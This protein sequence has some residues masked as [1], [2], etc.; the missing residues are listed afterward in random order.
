MS[1]NSPNTSSVKNA[2]LDYRDRGYQVI[3]VPHRSKNPG[4]VDWPQLRLSREDVEKQFADQMNVGVLLGEPSGWIV[5]VDIDHPK[6][7][8]IADQYLPQTPAVF[9]RPGNPR[10]HRI[11]RVTTPVA[12]KKY[13]SKSAGTII[14]LRSTG[15]QTVFPPSTHECG[16]AIAWESDGAEPALVDP[17]Q[18]L[19]AV[20]A[21]ADQV[22]IELGEKAKPAA[23]KEKPHSQV[24]SDAEPTADTRVERCLRAMSRISTTDSNDGSSRLFTAACRCVEHDL[25]DAESIDAIRQ[26]SMVQPFPKDWSDE[27]ILKRVRDAENRCTRGEANTNQE[28]H[29]EDA[30]GLSQAARLVTLAG[31]MELFRSGDEA[32]ATFDV[33]DHRE[34]HA[35]K[36]KA[37]K[38]WLCR[39]YF[40][41]T[42]H[43][44]TSSALTDA[45]AVLNGQAMFGGKELPVA[46]RLAEHDGA[47]WLDLGDERWRAIR[48]DRTGWSVVESRN[49]PVRFLHRR[50]MRPLPEPVRGGNIGELRSFLNLRS[51]DDWA[52]CLAF[53]VGALRPSGPF[54]VLHIGGEHGTAKSSASRVLRSLIDP[55]TA[56]IRCEPKEPRDL[57]IAAS[58]AWMI[59]FD[60]LSGL[61]SW[62]SDALCRLA[63][64]GGFSTRELYSDGDETIFNAK[65]PVILNGIETIATKPDLLDRCINLTLELIP[66]N[67]RRTESDLD[68][69]FD[70]A[71][72]RILGALLD[73]VAM[74]MSRCAEV[75]LV[76]LPRMADFAVWVVAAEPALGLKPGAFLEAYGRDRAAAH[77]HTVENSALA[78]AINLLLDGPSE[79]TGTPGE[80]LKALND[81]RITDA[82]IRKA[83]E[84][85]KNARSLSGQL[86]RL[87]PSLRATG[88]AVTIPTRRTGHDKKL[89]IVLKKMGDGHTAHTAHTAN[90]V[91]DEESRDSTRSVGPD[92]HPHD[93]PQHSAPDAPGEPET[94]S[95]ECAVHAECESRPFHVGASSPPAREVFRL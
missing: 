62:L 23:P 42:Q 86:R 68:R 24:K 6:A 44:P 79:W 89:V 93:S 88:I 1:P 27:E 37:F 17:E 54:P 53:L 41:A 3:P 35:L 4:I 59:V 51:D 16:E 72:P 83:T 50:A 90:A 22:K 80:L 45:L 43:V 49:V 26:Y 57:M 10:S 29:D 13:K 12:T 73:A 34:T 5:D 75:R 15:Q 39:Q 31:A 63:T 52:L 95:A 76:S 56:P 48:I 36:T 87:A 8:E 30:G 21:I 70:E 32:Y 55:N 67:K 18:L 58:N 65:R 91:S 7:L 28:S 25:T 60:N 78:A 20:K 92:D 66:D 74:A 84:W 81:D 71:H 2:A 38:I 40:A 33:G 11:Y 47:I 85:P 69:E 82:Q 94:P 19:A 61:P 46:V 64:G 9:G 77:E 14:E